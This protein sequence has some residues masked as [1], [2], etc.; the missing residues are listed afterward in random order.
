MDPGAH[1][2]PLTIAEEALTAVLT[3]T[4]SLDRDELL[5]SRLTREET[6][7]HLLRAA[8]AL[9]RIARAD[10]LALAEID[11]GAWESVAL[12]LPRRDGPAEESLWSAVH[13]L[14]PATLLWL[15]VHRAR[16]PEPLRSPP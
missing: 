11:W 2:N 3:L 13:T 15:R 1:E 12:H 5:R 14:A 8:E 7:R 6:R 16:R 10:Q 4:E 9:A